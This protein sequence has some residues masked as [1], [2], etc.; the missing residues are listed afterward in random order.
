LLS[1]G[2]DRYLHIWNVA[3]GAELKKLGPTPDDPFGIALSRDGKAVATIGY[4]GHLILWDL[5]QGKIQSMRKL[6]P[7]AYCIT[8]APDGKAVVTGHEDGTCYI[9][10]VSAPAR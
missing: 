4:G 10:P 9:T 2:F 1:V 8:F 3:T 6:K 7:V 5:E